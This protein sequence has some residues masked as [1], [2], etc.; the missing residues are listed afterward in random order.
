MSLA[1]VTKE[2]SRTF[3]KPYFAYYPGTKGE[4]IQKA[5]ELVS[6]AIDAEDEPFDGIIGFSQGAAL[7]ISYLMHHQ[8]HNPDMPLPFQFGVLFSAGASISPDPEY[9]QVEIMSFLTKL[10]S[11]DI[12]G[13]HSG[14]VDQHSYST[15]EQME[16]FEKLTPQ[17]RLIASTLMRHACGLV[18]SRRSLSIKD[19]NAF[20][21][22]TKATDITL[23]DFPRFFHPIYTTERIAIPTVHISGAYD[24]EEIA[25]LAAVNRELCSGGKMEIIRHDGHH[26]I[27][28]KPKEVERIVS[29]IKRAAYVGQL[30][31]EGS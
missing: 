14:L 1:E 27:P 18:G 24:S 17:E 10:T 22:G 25:M 21:D 3:S 2:F 31:A 19:S 12:Q 5:H 6:A 20:W 26:E 4:S 29:A 13:L 11:D 23:D 9:K 15:A 28:R 16:G 30:L 8:T 7:A